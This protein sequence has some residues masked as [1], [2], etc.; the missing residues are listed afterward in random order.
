M[1]R[2]SIGRLFNAPVIFLAAMAA[3][4]AA[5][6]SRSMAVEVSQT[7]Y[8]LRNQSLL[9]TDIG[10]PAPWI[11][12]YVLPGVDESLI[13]WETRLTGDLS[14]IF[15][16]QIDVVESPEAARLEA[17]FLVERDGI[18]QLLA[19]DEFDA[20]AL[21]SGV[22]QPVS[23]ILSGIDAQTADG[24]RLIFH[25]KLLSGGARVGI[26]IDGNSAH[27]DSSVS[28]YFN[29]PVA[30]FNHSTPDEGND[31][32]IRFD[33]GCSTDADGMAANLFYRWDWD[34]DG[35]F[36]TPYDASASVIHEFETRGIKRVK[37]NV[38]DG[39]G[40]ERTLTRTIPIP[41]PFTAAFT[42]PDSAPMG[43]AWDGY[44]LWH[45]DA[46]SRMIHQ[47]THAGDIV[48]SFASPCENPLDL[49]WDGHHL[50]VLDAWGADDKGNI[51]YQVDGEGAVLKTLQLP[52]DISTGLAWDGHY[53]W[54][55][56][57]TNA[58]IV[59]IDPASGEII[60]S[61]S[62]PGPS[63]RG[64][65]WDGRYLW[66]ADISTAT[67]YQLTAAGTVRNAFPA[68]GA[69]PMGLAFD[70]ANLWCV[71][72]ND[73]T[74][75]FTP[76]GR[77]QI[78]PTG[79]AL[80]EPNGRGAF[81]IRLDRRPLAPVTIGLAVSDPEEIAAPSE[82]ILD[83]DNWN[84]GVSVAVNVRD[85]PYA[86]GDRRC[87]VITRIATS[88]DAYFH[89]VNPPDVGV[90]ARDDD[91]PALY[92]EAAAPSFGMVGQAWTTTLQG[93]GFDADMAVYLFRRDDTGDIISESRIETVQVTD[94][95]TAEL[96]IP[97]QTRVG[98]CGLRLERGTDDFVLESAISILEDA[99]HATQRRRKAILVAGGG[100]YPGNL[101]WNA[102]RFSIGRAW[103]TLISQGYAADRLRL[104][105]AD[106]ILD[107]D[108]D[109]A[110][111][112]AAG[113]TSEALAA[114]LAGWARQPAQ[115]GDG[116][117]EEVLI[118]LTG[119]GG[120]GRFELAPDDDLNAAV[121]DGWLD[122]LQQATGCRLIVII[123]ACRSA[124]FLPHLDAPDG[125][126]DRRIVIASSAASE[127][128]WFVNDGRLSFSNYFW[129]SVYDKGRLYQAYLDARQR[130][131]FDQSPS[132]DRTGDG[133]ADVVTPAEPAVDILIG[134]GRVAASVIP[135]IGGVFA[136]APFLA[137]Q[138][139]TTFS[140][141][142]IIAKNG[143]DGVWA[144][145]MPP[146]ENPDPSVPLLAL[147]AVL[148]TDTDGDGE[149]TGGYAGFSENGLYTV[150]IYAIDKS[151]VQSIPLR[152]Q[153]TR[154]CD[155]PMVAGDV[156]ADGRTDL[157]DAV[158]ALRV[159]AGMDVTGQLR[160]D[161]TASGVDLDGDKRAGPAEAIYALGR[162]ALSSM[163][164]PP[165][166]LFGESE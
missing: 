60:L 153:V 51:L 22:Y 48:R 13:F 73:Y 58:R 25:I 88:P 26:G 154:A 19:S 118:Y 102:T 115:A 56:D 165:L 12:R 6:P 24:D 134:R 120:D 145:V 92:I 162:A 34:A 53:L 166:T 130:V 127:R 90:L 8:Y 101:L 65:A 112:V 132:I 57:G 155:A 67:L 87:S 62:S 11:T 72:Q 110:N 40:R 147:P 96:T 15:S 5:I 37:L 55:A 16:Y 93:G 94:A 39:Q 52:A 38:R 138:T 111:D 129:S 2:Q 21:P 105:S 17:A 49:A 54:G 23:A 163:N 136:A 14:D 122:A 35:V 18:Y 20:P 144:R 10:A 82:V 164:Q 159:V 141:R 158:V 160:P 29:G 89:G 7:R 142:S 85:D 133:A 66:V 59:K 75:Y 61:F 71:D 68:P 137:C 36:D 9:S 43:L 42:A 139:Q 30:C 28:L 1:K 104:L 143:I 140:A 91:T 114:T 157:A 106:P 124:S 70:G 63:P 113:A 3:A 146:E 79:L 109:G 107:A 123:D 50:W 86:D 100:P 41:L 64:L 148:L 27:N 103:H 117:P 156:T 121:F 152:T 125:Y 131:A 32:Q 76:L 80:W 95:A 99:D 4:F 135:E 31:L 45:S 44:Y 149:Y 150:V 74:A 116:P 83:A 108:A 47:M 98:Q 46:S 81:T 151:G 128:A 33:A 77:I 97:A 84:T 161:F 78:Y 126:A 69:A 119:H